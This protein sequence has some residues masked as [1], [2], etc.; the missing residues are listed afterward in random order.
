MDDQSIIY[1]RGAKQYSD[2]IVLMHDHR[3][4]LYETVSTI[5]RCFD[6]DDFITFNKRDRFFEFKFEQLE[7]EAKK[8]VEIIRKL[9]VPRVQNNHRIDWKAMKLQLQE[10][11]KNLGDI[12]VDC[13]NAQDILSAEMDFEIV[14][15]L[16]PGKHL[17]ALPNLF[18]GRCLEIRARDYHQIE[19]YYKHKLRLFLREEQIL[20][21]YI[22][23]LLKLE[24]RARMSEWHS[25]GCESGP[26][27][28]LFK[29][30]RNCD[31]SHKV[32]KNF[33]AELCVPEVF[34][35]IPSK[36]L[37]IP[38][39]TATD[40]IV[41]AIKHYVMNNISSSSQIISERDKYLLSVILPYVNDDDYECDFQSTLN[42]IHPELKPPMISGLFNHFCQ[43]FEYDA[44]SAQMFEPPKVMED[45]DEKHAQSTD[46]NSDDNIIVNIAGGELNDKSRMISNDDESHFY[47]VDAESIKYKLLQNLSHE[48]FEVVKQYWLCIFEKDTN[49]KNEKWTFY[50]RRSNYDQIFNDKR[51]KP[52]IET[53]TFQDTFTFNSRKLPSD[54]RL[55]LIIK[56][57]D[58][59]FEYDWGMWS[60][61]K[62][63]FYTNSTGY[64]RLLKDYTPTARV[65]VNH[66][67]CILALLRHSVLSI[68]GDL[69]DRSHIGVAFL[70]D[71]SSD[72]DT[73]SYDYSEHEVEAEYKLQWW[74]DKKCGN[75]SLSLSLEK[76]FYKKYDLSLL[77]FKR[78]KD[79]PT[80]FIH[81]RAY[82]NDIQWMWYNNDEA[83]FKEY[84]FKSSEKTRRVVKQLEASYQ[85]V[86]TDNFPLKRFH[87]KDDIKSH[88][89]NYPALQEMSLAMQEMTNFL[90]PYVARFTFS[91]N[92]QITNIE[93]IAV[94]SFYE[95]F[96]RNVNRVYNGKNSVMIYNEEQRVSM[97]GT[98]EVYQTKNKNEE[99]ISICWKFMKNPELG[100][101]KTYHYHTS[102]SHDSQ[103]KKLL[104]HWRA[105]TL[106]DQNMHN[107]KIL[108][109]QSKMWQRDRSMPSVFKEYLDMDIHTKADEDLGDEQSITVNNSLYKNNNDKL[110]LFKDRLR[111]RNETCSVCEQRELDL[112]HRI[113][114]GEDARHS[115][116]DSIA[117]ARLSFADITSV[118][119]QVS[120]EDWK[121]F[122]L[123]DAKHRVVGVTNV[124]PYYTYEPMIL[125][126]NTNG[127]PVSNKQ[128][129]Q[130]KDKHPSERFREKVFDLVSIAFVQSLISVIEHQYS[131]QCKPHT[132][133]DD[134]ISD[135]QPLIIVFSDDPNLF[136]RMFQSTD[137]IAFE[138]TDTHSKSF[139][140]LFD[141]NHY[142][143]HTLGD[144]HRIDRNGN[145]YV[146][147]SAQISKYLLNSDSFHEFMSAITIL[148]RQSLVLF[149]R[150]CSTT[151]ICNIYVA[152]DGFVSKL[153]LEMNEDMHYFLP[154][155]ITL[156][157]G[158]SV[159][160]QAFS[161]PDPGTIVE[162]WK[163]DTHSLDIKY[164]IRG[165]DNV[166]YVLNYYKIVNRASPMEYYDIVKNSL[167]NKQPFCE[168]SLWPKDYEHPSIDPSSSTHPLHGC[169]L[170]L[171]ESSKQAITS[172]EMNTEMK[173]NDHNR[174][175]IQHKLQKC[176]LLLM[177]YRSVV[178]ERNEEVEEY[179]AEQE[180][181][182]TVPADCMFTLS[183]FLL[184]TFMI[185]CC[186]Q[187]M[188]K[189]F[190]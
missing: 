124:E 75:S 97:I 32:W 76:P 43:I 57:V 33:Y 58:D 69:F 177:F 7:R 159:Q 110:L 136:G 96:P 154:S 46:D 164:R 91:D 50:V 106:F 103:F 173:M 138:E 168:L 128:F 108:I 180:D 111:N 163:P 100:L 42:H 184:F 141:D 122:D 4:F 18:F 160:I 155:F 98:M 51:R 126:I 182:N 137:D 6:C 71:L 187:W 23:H 67:D 9:S 189:I 142:P 28:F 119:K 73:F 169:V 21:R 99:K 172:I 157:K 125:D 79:K 116:S 74:N 27:W 14:M 48:K 115:S 11:Y 94:N 102:I 105:N 171:M 10:L 38:R 139:Y 161:S 54:Q 186:L 72:I 176:G 26:L 12:D 84:L 113:K 56:C 151:N 165:N 78:W 49:G 112:T 185:Y 34:N 20:F 44:S 25:N 37:P 147:S 80:H 30:L 15:R 45:E 35:D 109:Q 130:W 127:I 53:Y 129:E 13:I 89:F 77:R 123:L 66:L 167:L 62:V 145:I 93:Q 117:I 114:I 81:F 90:K 166:F 40:F 153:I 181:I 92:G 83:T 121:V 101:N 143:E 60:K 85:G 88:L 19:G 47:R 17:F 59:T 131:A 65:P 178:N 170:A 39:Q 36:S 31:S 132:H 146:I 8:K 55:Y 104:E 41:L 179:L 140:H 188:K 52:D 174:T 133:D 150:P 144:I 1:A 3:R 118:S 68:S 63:R 152:H 87:I 175:I 16:A 107:R 5:F 162:F 149:T 24:S 148:D 183:L 120:D 134:N 82:D 2:T 95:Q 22:R 135:E 64:W 70:S 156:S 61:K 158:D 29:L 190:R 86:L